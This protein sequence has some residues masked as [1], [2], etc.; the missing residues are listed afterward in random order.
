VR[1]E[2]TVGKR[3]G[4][5]GQTRG[6]KAR[7]VGWTEGGKAG[8]GWRDKGKREVGWRDRGSETEAR[9]KQT[10]ERVKAQMGKYTTVTL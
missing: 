10:R 8:V 6:C 5:K 2:R 9:R 7:D 1:M 4:R 3:E